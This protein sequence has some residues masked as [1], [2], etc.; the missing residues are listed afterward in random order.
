MK[1]FFTRNLLAVICMA[2][3]VVLFAGCGSKTVEKKLMIKNLT[4]HPIMRV[5]I[6]TQEGRKD[7][8]KRTYLVG[9]DDEPMAPS[10]EREVTIA[11]KE[12]DLTEEWYLTAVCDTDDASVGSEDRMGKIWQD[13]VDGFE[14]YFDDNKEYDNFTYVSLYDLY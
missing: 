9:F 1:K 2:A 3:I 11:V 14:I 8:D 12:K 7:S 10:E 4:D 5:D 6:A 13:G